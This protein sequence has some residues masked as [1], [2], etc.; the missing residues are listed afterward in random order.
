MP[1]GEPVP[2]V[3][4]APS[5]TSSAV[6]A[7]SVP[8]R[9]AGTTLVVVSYPPAQFVIVDPDHTTATPLALPAGLDPTFDSYQIVA[10]K[11]AVVVLGC[12][13][14]GA[15]HDAVAVY[16][17]PTLLGRPVRLG[18]ATHVLPS[19]EPDR[20]WLTS[21]LPG[22]GTPV[23]HLREVDMGGHQTRSLA[24]S[25]PA[26]AFVSLPVVPLSAGIVTTIGPVNGSPTVVLTNWSGKATTLGAGTLVAAAG[27]TVVWW[28]A[29]VL[30]ILDFVT[31]AERTVALPEPVGWA[32]AISPDGTMLAAAG[33]GTAGR[34]SIV[35]HQDAT[36]TMGPA[37]GYY[38]AVWDRS[39][40]EVFFTDPDQHQVDAWQ[41]AG[42][43]LVHLPVDLR[44]PVAVAVL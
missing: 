32:S 26:G 34:L 38:R 25:A 9:S 36:V 16:A 23:L 43:N 12:I 39:S 42:R 8:G 5:T 14:T 30:H 24:I 15:G 17:Y 29:G 19:A 35:D 37:F 31:H 2:V 33:V 44:E 28:A 40:R 27:T 11:G 13:D 20:V 3:T 7:T 4:G 41:V 21:F 18:D 22:L 6:E 1:F 10:R